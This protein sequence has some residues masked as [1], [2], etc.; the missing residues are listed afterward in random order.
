MKRV[1]RSKRVFYSYFDIVNNNRPLFDNDIFIK[2]AF[3]TPAY[4]NRYMSS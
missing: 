4:L 1:T 3:I 2:Q